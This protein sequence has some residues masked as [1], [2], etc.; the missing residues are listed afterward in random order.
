[1]SGHPIENHSDAVAM[2][3]IDEVHELVGLAVTRGR[4]EVTDGL[5]TP[6]P[7]VRVFG[8]RQQF[9]MRIAELFDVVDQGVGKLAIGEITIAFFGSPHPRA[10]MYFVNRHRGIE[11]VFR[12]AAAHPIFIA[13]M[14]F[15]YVVD[16]GGCLGTALE[17]E[18]VRIG[19][20][21][22]ESEAP[23]FDFEFVESLFAKTG[24]KYLPDTRARMK[25]HRVPAS[26][27]MIEIADEADA[28]RV[29][30]PH[31]EVNAAN[32]VDHPHVRAELFVVAIVRAF[33]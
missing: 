31:R 32:A 4:R 10:K 12:G 30:R 26:I 16:D 9:D 17:V 1:M 23:P 21:N 5:I 2:T 22:F 3:V 15:V 11:S 28:L 20:L 8:H 33:L 14:I 24:N 7:V 13:P 25:A 19:L 29:G 6:T 18:R 27:P